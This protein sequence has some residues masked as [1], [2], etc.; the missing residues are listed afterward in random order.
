MMTM[1]RLDRSSALH[2]NPTTARTTALDWER[3]GAD[4]PNR[5]ASRFVTVGAMRWHVQ[6]MGSGPVLLLLHGTGASSHSWR[7]LAPRLAR[8]FTV[9]APDLPG[10]GFSAQPAA[11][12]YSLSAFAHAIAALVAALKMQPALAVGHS[13]GAAVLVRMA[14]A[15]TLPGAAIVSLNGALLPLPGL[16]GRVF[17]PL[18]RILAGVPQV[19]RMFA[20]HAAAS[21]LVDRL[22]E[23]TGSRVDA[24]GVALYARLACNPVHVAAA[25]AMMAQWNLAELKPHLARL[26]LPLNL[27]AAGNDL[28]IPPHQAE[29][30]AGMVPGAALTRL[31]GLGHLAHE[32]APRRIAALILAL[33]RAHRR[34]GRP[35][36]PTGDAR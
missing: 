5:A 36:A 8:H 4:W 18:A 1:P 29:T 28:T 16:P 3:D 27:V 2:T 6:V 17:G 22:L 23:Q 34:A 15:R 13:A 9:L 25:L 12:G 24:Q 11:H 21:P 14:L 31:P 19:P 35:G 33:A 10:H 30:L 26:D 7:D 32:E 20:R